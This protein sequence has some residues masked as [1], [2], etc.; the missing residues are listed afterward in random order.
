MSKSKEKTV[1]VPMVGDLIHHGH[2]N[3]ISEAR[4]YGNIIVGLMTDKAAASYKRLPLLA[5]EQ[6]K[7]IVE[8]LAGVVE[9]VPQDILDYVPSI[10]KIKPDYFVH[11]DDWK[12]GVQKPARARVIAALKKYGGK[13][14]R[15]LIRH[16]KRLARRQTCVLSACADYSRQSLLSAA[17]RCTTD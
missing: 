10:N 3:V 6:R 7:K 13:L 14:I 4:K 11:G 5:Y 12:T 16:L 15:R 9:V 8:N 1:Y 17:S 2:V